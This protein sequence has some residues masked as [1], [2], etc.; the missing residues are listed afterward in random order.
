ME[1]LQRLQPLDFLM[2]VLWA[3]IVGWGLQTGLIRQLGM[4]LGV[5]AGAVLA[6]SVY[7][8]VGQV[9]SLAFGRGVLPQCEFF[10]YIGSFI[11]VFGVMGVLM[12]RV[13][14]LTRLTRGWGWD[15]V[16]GG[17][18]AA[19]W[20]ASLLVVLVTSLRYY[21]LTPW[22]GQEATQQGVVTQVNASQVAPVLQLALSPLWQVMTPWFPAIVPPRL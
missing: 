14:P 5:Y 9:L 16:A 21:T 10:A 3:A 6:G 13:Y 20:G 11:L 8:P 4:L 19:I 18:V 22:R 2:V 17:M 15:N 12:W 7:R 1:A